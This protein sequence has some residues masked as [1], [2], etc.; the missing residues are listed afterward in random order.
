VAR[1]AK[2]KQYTIDE[3]QQWVCGMSVSTTLAT[4]LCR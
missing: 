3:Q 1:D 2:S 4:E